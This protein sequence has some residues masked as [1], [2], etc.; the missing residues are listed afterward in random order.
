MPI[1]KFFSPR[2]AAHALGASESSLKRWVD[3]GDLM[4]RRTTG[5]HRRIPA[6][7]VLRFAR[8]KGIALRNPS[9]IGKAIPAG[10]E[11]LTTALT[12]ALIA[13]NSEETQR[14]LLRA[15]LDGIE[16]PALVDGPVRQ[17]LE[18]IGKRWKHHD[19]GAEQVDE[20]GIACE[21]Q[22]TIL[23]MR[24][25]EALRGVLP[26]P[27]EDAPIAVGGGPAGD[28]YF[29]P[30]L[31]VSLV[32]Q[33]VGW[34]AVDLGPDTPSNVLIAAAKQHG[35]H[36][37]WRSFSGDMN[38]QHASEELIRI[39]NEL[40]MCRVVVGGCRAH[41]LTGLDGVANLVRATSMTELSRCASRYASQCAIVEV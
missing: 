8:R 14:L 17:A 19:A 28:P 12:Q 25:A 41:L 7:E 37:V 29:L 15:H 18:N 38:A 16:I 34:R 10:G 23:V 5:G 2:Q 30:S 3:A 26:A 9:A 32:L 22:A 13:G 35:A 39:C 27:S 40:P 36:L 4:I 6:A 31:F 33:S 24:A 11:G 1:Q 20:A 21:H